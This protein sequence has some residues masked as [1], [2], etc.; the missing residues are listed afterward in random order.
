MRVVHFVAGWAIA[1]CVLVLRLTCRVRLHDDPRPALRMRRVPYAYAVL[2]AHQVAAVF[3]AEP[4]TGAMVSRSA[5]GDLL[6]PSLRVRH[7][8]PVRGSTRLRGRDKGGRAALERLIEHVRGGLPAYLAVDGPRG[9]RGEVNR[10][11]ALLAQATG[12]AVV[13]A[14]P[15]PTR[16]WILS[17][18]WDRLQIPKPFAA[19]DVHF[20]MLAPLGVAEEPE[21]L[22]LRVQETLAALE[23][24]HDAAEARL[25]AQ[26]AARRREKLERERVASLLSASRL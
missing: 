24:E 12:A 2:H 26:A 4:G 7:V 8:M 23:H 1:L 15:V 18:T 20:R 11:I 10:G 25:G 19:I 17:G 5:D 13:A 21:A 14:L 6:V 9:P 22:R 16:R 3:A